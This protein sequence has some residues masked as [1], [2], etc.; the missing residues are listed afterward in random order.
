MPRHLARWWPHPRPP[1]GAP[2]FGRRGGRATVAGPSGASDTVA[3][4]AQ[5]E[6][7]RRRPCRPPGDARPPTGHEGRR[8]RAVRRR[9]LRGAGRRAGPGR[10]ATT[11]WP[12][13]PWSSPPRPGSWPGHPPTA[14]PPGSGR[15]QRRVLHPGHPG[16]RIGR[17]MGGG[18]RPATGDP[19]RAGRGRAV[20]AGRPC[21]ARALSSV[22]DQP[23]AV[24]ALVQT[25]QELR[26]LARGPRPGGGPRRPAGRRWSSAHDRRGRPSGLEELLRR[27][28]PPGGGDRRR[29]GRSRGVGPVVVYLPERLRHVELDAAG[30]AIG[31]VGGRLT[32]VI[33]TTGDPVADGP[34]RDLVCPPRAP[35]GRGGLRP[36]AAAGAGEVG[37]PAVAS[38]APGPP[39]PRSSSG[40]V[41]HLMAERR[42]GHA[43][44]SGMAIAHSGNA[45]YRGFGTMS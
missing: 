17:A 37:G 8:R 21:A 25:C 34:A 29:A 28:G 11:P 10:G 45:P 20:R 40:G 27:R 22:P 14:G 33:G 2:S 43:A 39:T 18:H 1:G 13:S 15:R 36:R 41:R 23:G 12:R 26:A 9:R 31:A 5:A 44:W 19:G 35:R 42:P 6:W 16:R 7:H 32:A 24:R 3:G 30:Q 38:G 4:P